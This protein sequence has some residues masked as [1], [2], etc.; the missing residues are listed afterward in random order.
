M[1]FES[2]LPFHAR[3]WQ[4]EIT[5]PLRQSRVRPSEILLRVTR[6]EGRAGSATSMRGSGAGE[7][8]GDSS[9]ATARRSIHPSAAAATGR[10]SWFVVASQR[11]CSC[12]S[13]VNATRSRS[14]CT[15]DISR[16]PVIRDPAVSALV[17]SDLREM[18]CRR[19]SDHWKTPPPPLPFESRY[20]RRIY[21]SRSTD[22]MTVAGKVNLP[23]LTIDRE[24][25][26]D[27]RA[28]GQRVEGS[29][30][31]GTCLNIRAFDR[32]RLFLS[33]K[34]RRR[35]VIVPKTV[36]SKYFQ[37]L[38]LFDTFYAVVYKHYP[39]DTLFIVY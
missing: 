17:R 7:G 15:P 10:V 9:R 1:S 31:H 21:A 13:S 26:R 22:E 34:F 16:N 33:R 30:N 12:A 19:P 8:V 14:I 5:W 11:A 35:A 2:C 37:F 28:S 29:L 4:V 24:S 20:V 38:I 18:C 6:G 23:D 3:P 25:S 27:S 39:R 32:W 36:C